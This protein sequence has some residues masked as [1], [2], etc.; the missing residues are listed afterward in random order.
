MAPFFSW[1]LS[2]LVDKS[3]LF[4]ARGFV[5]SDGAIGARDPC[6]SVYVHSSQPHQ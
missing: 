3:I 1:R 6:S 2:G 5:R 4:A